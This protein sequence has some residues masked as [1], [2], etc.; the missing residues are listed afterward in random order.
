MMQAWVVRY[1][2]VD[3]GSWLSSRKVLISPIAL[4]QPKWPEKVLPVPI[5]KEQ[6]KNSPD[7]DTEKPVSRQHEIRTS[8]ITVIPIIGGV[9]DS[10]AAGVYPN[11]MMPGYAG[12]ASA[13]DRSRSQRQSK[14][15]TG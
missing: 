3:T 6:V 12:F 9:P 1:L 15:S 5:T 11:M 10:G 8:D 7:I 13:P 4:G 2:V 14:L